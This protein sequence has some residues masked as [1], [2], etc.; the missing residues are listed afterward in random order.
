MWVDFNGYGVH[1][2]IRDFGRSVYLYVI[3][4]KQI[5]RNA[6]SDMLL[7]FTET[8]VTETPLEEGAR[9]TDQPSLIIPNL[10]MDAMVAAVQGMASTMMGRR[11]LT[12]EITLQGKLDATE[13]HLDDM[14]RLLFHAHSVSFPISEK[15]VSG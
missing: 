7:R 5:S 2:E 15:K 10:A 11:P 1:A 13:R 9:Y 14:R 8:G 3:R 6:T 4:S 12:A